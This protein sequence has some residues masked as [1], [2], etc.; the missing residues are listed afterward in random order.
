MSN[1]DEGYNCDRCGKYVENIRESELYLRYVIG[2]VPHAELPREPERHIRC[3]PEF[4][5]YIVDPAFEAVPCEDAALSKQG[6]PEDVRVRQEELFTK[7]WL[8][9]QELAE[10][11]TPVDQYPMEF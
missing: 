6:L 7:A 10:D 2:A 4:A 1:C 11:G 8:R 3:A 5:Q 9:L